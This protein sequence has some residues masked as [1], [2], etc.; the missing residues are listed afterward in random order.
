MEVILTKP[1]MINDIL[2]GHLDEILIQ[3]ICVVHRLY[4]QVQQTSIIYSLYNAGYLHL[5]Q[6]FG[7]LILVSTMALYN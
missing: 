4:E 2:L 7:F 6:N 1:L 3:S 5:F